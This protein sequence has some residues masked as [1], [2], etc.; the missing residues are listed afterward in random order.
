MA[1]KVPTEL[2]RK[3]L[4]EELREVGLTE[5]KIWEILNKV[6]PE[7]HEP[8]RKRAR[9][10][11]VQKLPDEVVQEYRRELWLRAA[12]RKLLRRERELTMRTIFIGGTRILGFV[13]QGDEATLWDL[14]K[15]EKKRAP[16]TRRFIAQKLPPV[17]VRTVDVRCIIVAKPN[18]D[19]IVLTFPSRSSGVTLTPDLLRERPSVVLLRVYHRNGEIEECEVDFENWRDIVR[20]IPPFCMKCLKVEISV[21]GK[22]WFNAV[23][24]LPRK[25]R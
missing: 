20:S 8:H 22:R 14:R 15:T 16:S 19:E 18:Q 13:R 25:E 10:V 21:D 4:A 1:T 17:R 5:E 7:K 6:L 3:Y 24:I 12:E 2:A 23:E 9:L 11:L